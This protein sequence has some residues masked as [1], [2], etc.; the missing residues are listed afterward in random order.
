MFNQL[1]YKQKFFA[2]I[3]IFVLLGLATYKKTYKQLFSANTELRHVEQKLSTAQGSYDQVIYLKNELNYLDAIIGGNNK[4]EDVQQQLLDFIIKSNIEVNVIT[5]SDVH[6][7][8]ENEF[9]IVTNQIELSGNYE[10][11]V[12]LLYKIEKEFNNSR[13]SNIEF[14]SKKNYR[15]NTKKLFLKITLH[16][17]EKNK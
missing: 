14:Y 6:I 15:T 12:S 10:D 3:L 11:L 2:V 4:A 16:N 7:F 5:I 1:T 13:V 8:E 17:Y 9:N